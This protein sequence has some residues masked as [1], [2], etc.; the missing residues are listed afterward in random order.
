MTGKKKSRYCVEM[1]SLAQQGLYSNVN[2]G[3]NLTER[4]LKI[5]DHSTK[6]F[7]IQKKYVGEMNLHLN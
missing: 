7:F 5:Q 1:I 6:K 4:E 2:G 3:K